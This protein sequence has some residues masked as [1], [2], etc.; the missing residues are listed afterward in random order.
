MIQTAVGIEDRGLMR[1][2]CIDTAAMPDGQDG[3]RKFAPVIEIVADCNA[4]A[5][6]QIA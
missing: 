1:I 4:V 2:F 6:R 5:G 3:S